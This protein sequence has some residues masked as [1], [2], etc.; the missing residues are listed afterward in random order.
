MATKSKKNTSSKTSKKPSPKRAASKSKTKAPE[1][2]IVEESKG[3]Y[4]STPIEDNNNH[5]N[6]SLPEQTPP[7]AEPEYKQDNSDL[8][9]ENASYTNVS[10]PYK[11]KDNSMAYI[12]GGLVLVILMWAIFA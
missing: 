2:I 7:P 8:I 1:A 11:E 5:T 4:T 12:V 10:M 3:I 9:Q 6:I